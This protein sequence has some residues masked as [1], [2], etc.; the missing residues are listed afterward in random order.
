ME[1]FEQNK[2]TNLLPYDGEVVYYGKVMMA[3]AA[4][5]YLDVLLIPSNGKR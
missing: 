2:T 3:T 1:L 4:D 5:H